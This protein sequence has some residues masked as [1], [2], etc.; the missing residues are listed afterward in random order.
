MENTY[1]F[2]PELLGLD[3]DHVRLAESVIKGKL[4]NP[5][6][7]VQEAF[8]LLGVNLSMLDAKTDDIISH[9]IS[10]IHDRNFANRQ[11]VLA[12]LNKI[13]GE[14]GFKVVVAAADNY[15]AWSKMQQ[16]D[17]LDCKE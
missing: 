13:T 10:N 1:K 8:A 9:I 11:F 16:F 5:T 4:L 3:Q 7:E 15:A 17:D 6:S 2:N 12:Q 14:L